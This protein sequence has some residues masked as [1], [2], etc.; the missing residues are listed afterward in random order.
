MIFI[1][2]MW[3]NMKTMSML[4]NESCEKVIPRPRNNLI[5]QGNTQRRG[6]W[7]QYRHTHGSP[8][9]GDAWPR[10]S[11]GARMHPSSDKHFS[12]SHFDNFQLR[13]HDSQVKISS[14][15][16]SLGEVASAIIVVGLLNSFPLLSRVIRRSARWGALPSHDDWWKRRGFG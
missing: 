13:N 8:G 3:S 16:Q 5:W 15:A 1:S 10:R 7:T 6:R 12:V 11:A 2:F 4:I 9:C 14:D